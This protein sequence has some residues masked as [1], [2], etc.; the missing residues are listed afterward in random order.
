MEVCLRAALPQ[1][2]II[3]APWTFVNCYEINVYEFSAV[4]QMIETDRTAAEQAHTD[5][6][7]FAR[8][9]T[10]NTSRHS[11]LTSDASS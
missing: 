9:Q 3:G 7:P 5:N 4:S 6:L 2:I 1:Q 10:Y 11:H 8:I